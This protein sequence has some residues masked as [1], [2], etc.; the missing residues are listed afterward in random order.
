MVCVIHALLSM[1]RVWHAW[2]EELVVISLDLWVLQTNFYLYLRWCSGICERQV[3]SG[4]H[5]SW[6][7]QCISI[8]FTRRDCE[9]GS[10][11]RLPSTFRPQWS[12]HWG[13]YY[14]SCQCSWWVPFTSDIIKIKSLLLGLVFYNKCSIL[15]WR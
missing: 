2:N 10:L 4:L 3:C 8:H 11:P 9:T 13:C 1:K 7:G 14:C 15:N 12:Q 6:Y 5:T